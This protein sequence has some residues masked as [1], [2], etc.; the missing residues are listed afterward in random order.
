MN[1]VESETA[2]QRA[3]RL[4]HVNT[5]QRKRLVTEMAEQRA[6]RLE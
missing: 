4:E 5:P 2:E 6:F 1:C 3:A